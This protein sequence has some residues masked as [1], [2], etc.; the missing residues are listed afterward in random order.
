MND[1]PKF[2]LITHLTK[3]FQVRNGH[4]IEGYY[5][6]GLLIHL[7]FILDKTLRNNVH[8]FKWSK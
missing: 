6:Y 5:E 1:K 8:F 2:I 3:E 4:W 7:G